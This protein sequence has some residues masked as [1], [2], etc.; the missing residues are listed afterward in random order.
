VTDRRTPRRRYAR[1][2][3]ST[4]S[5]A[6]QQVFFIQPRRKAI[7]RQAAMQIAHGGFVVGG[8]AQKDAEGTISGG[9]CHSRS[10]T[11]NARCPIVAHP[12]LSV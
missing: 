10:S 3:I 7:V 11:M 2:W 6:G 4:A 5:L 9:I 1:L 12:P 8:M